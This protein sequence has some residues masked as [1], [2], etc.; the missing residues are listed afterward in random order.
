MELEDIIEVYGG[1]LLQ[2][3]GGICAMSLVAA[4]YA[5]GGMIFYIVQQYMTGICG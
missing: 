1:S 5:D 2:V 3:L 4:L